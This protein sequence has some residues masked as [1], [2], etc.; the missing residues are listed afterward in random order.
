MPVHKT[1]CQ[2]NQCF[3]VPVT[4]LE[5]DPRREYI[6]ARIH[7]N[8]PSCPDEV[9][10]YSVVIEDEW[11]NILD[12]FRDDTMEGAWLHVNYTLNKLG[13]FVDSE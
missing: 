6:R 3:M 9:G 10:F 12:S 13:V 1:T 2:Y 4:T 7:F 8:H 5:S 11:M